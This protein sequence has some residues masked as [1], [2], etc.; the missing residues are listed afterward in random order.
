MPQ[1]FTIRKKESKWCN[2]AGWKGYCNSLP[3][4]NY[5][6]SAPR[7]TRGRSNDQNKYYWAVC[8]PLVFSALK[9]AGFDTVR[10]EEDAHLI[11]KSL[12]LKVHEEKKGVRIERVQSTTELSTIMFAEYLLHIFTW[13]LDYLGLTIPQPNEQLTFEL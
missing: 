13:A 4:G 9:D 3:D 5:I 10:T 8:V 2:T 6:F 11:M 12:F 1:G 7:S